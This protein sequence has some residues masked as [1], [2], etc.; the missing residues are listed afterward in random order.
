M[1]IAIGIVCLAVTGGA[2]PAAGVELALVIPDGTRACGV[3]QEGRSIDREYLNLSAIAFR[4]GRHV[5]PL[6]AGAPETLDLVADLAVG[7]EREAAIPDGRGTVSLEIVTTAAPSLIFRYTY[8]QAFTSGGKPLSLVWESID[9]VFT[10]LEP[11]SRDLV[12]DEA[13]LA[14]RGFIAGHRGDVADAYEA[15]IFFASCSYESLPL[16]EYRVALP[17][18]DGAVLHLRYL[19]PFAGSGPANLVRAEVTLGG[20]RRVV[21]DYWRLAYAAEHHNWVQ[22]FLVLFDAPVGD[23]W[24]LWVDEAEW[25]WNGMPVAHPV[26]AGRKPLAD[27]SALAYDIERIQDPLHPEFLRADADQDAT[28]D[29]GDAIRIL[30]DLFAGDGTIRCPDADDVDD[31]GVLDIADPIRLL[32]HIFADGPRPAQPNFR[33]GKDPTPDDLPACEYDNGGCF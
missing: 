13:F 29:I 8:R 14:S 26:D 19:E 22:Q 2:A 28:L 9:F 15:R 32:N 3:F 12:V 5:L 21:E 6:T 1:D 24:G 23:A 16:F 4:A 27:L 18:G 10:T 7:P 20:E 25:P 31:S 11:E 17:D 33:C 30:D